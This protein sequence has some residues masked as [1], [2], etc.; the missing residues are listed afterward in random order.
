MPTYV[1][2]G[3][4]GREYEIEAP[5]GATE[6]DVLTYAQ[7]NYQAADAPQSPKPP[8][9]TAAE[10]T[11]I[12]DEQLDPTTGMGFGAK[13]LAGMG[14]SVSDSGQGLKQLGYMAAD[15][16]PGVDL[17][18]QRDQIQSEIDTAKVRD[19]P[20]MDTGA[21]LAGNI[22]GYGLQIA[23][24]GMAA[25]GTRLAG[26]VL[27][28]TF[29]GA[30]AQGAALGTLQP[31]ASDENR[32]ANAG[33]GAAAGIGGKA[34]GNALGALGNRAANSIDPVKRA[35]ARAAQRAGI[36]LHAAQVSDSIPAKTA[37]SM[38]KYLPFSGAAAAGQRQQTAFNRAVGR[39]FGEDKEQLT[40]DVIQSARQK[41]GAEFNAIYARNDV[42]IDPNTVRRL[43]ALENSL[44]RRL[45]T[46]ESKVLG[47]QLDDILQ[48]AAGTGAMTG[49]K[50][51]ALRTQI[52]KAESPDRIGSAVKELRRELDDI[53]AQAVGPQ[54]AAMLKK[55]RGQWANLKT[56]EGMLKQVAGAG[57]DVKPSAIWP[58]I[59]KGSTKEM[60]DLGRLGQVLLKDPIPD[61]G[62]A[63]RNLLVG[64]MTGGGVAGGAGAIAP[65]VGGTLAGAT[66]GRIA[67]SN[68]LAEFMLR[69]NAGATRKI[70]GKAVNR[71]AIP[72]FPAAKGKLYDADLE[73]M[74]G[75]G[76]EP[77]T[78][79]E[80]EQLRAEMRARRA[81]SG[82]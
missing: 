39:T 75:G 56:T 35:A 23:G 52:M 71:L 62:T 63:G 44:S 26:A 64:L 5:D 32:L 59:R 73:V 72:A 25:S 29:R 8:A 20:L 77:V 37:A 45:T 76:T 18:Q 3:P 60:R 57:G 67:N 14:K 82:K 33:M 31:V 17:S 6:A 79:A 42:P 55:I 28:T 13:F 43:V 22:A 27:P 1:V 66:V 36:P 34:A 46:D 61:S 65:M 4:D 74:G 50:Y 21:G 9:K 70:A 19:R 68:K 58:A 10:L 81:R 15:Q 40:D 7:Q 24:P 49:Q 11:G 41:I 2:T 38:G 47:A 12:T 16:I 53:A 80:L 54:D 48:E 69:S 30:A 51:Q 78:E